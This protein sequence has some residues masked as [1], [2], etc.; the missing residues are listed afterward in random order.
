MKYIKVFFFLICLMAVSLF[1]QYDTSTLN[2]NTWV[3][4]H[5]ASQPLSINGSNWAY[6]NDLGS[7]PFYPFFIMGPGH[8]V[9]PQDSYWYPYDPLANKWMKI[10]SPR[11]HP[12]S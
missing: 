8:V 2:D 7:H 10:N 6:E 5:P 12:R 1:A 4:V 9:H 11:R 3:N